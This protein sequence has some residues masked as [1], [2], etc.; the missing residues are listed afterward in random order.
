[1]TTA[2]IDYRLKVWDNRDQFWRALPGP[3]TTLQ[4]AIDRA[5]DL[6]IPRECRIGYP[7][8]SIWQGQHMVNLIHQTPRQ[9]LTGLAIPAP[10]SSKPAMSDKIPGNLTVVTAKEAEAMP[11]DTCFKVCLVSM[12]NFVIDIEPMD[13][14]TMEWDTD[15]NLFASSGWDFKRRS[16]AIHADD[17]VVISSKAGA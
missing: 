13:K 10:R 8:V 4:A 5:H 9:A 3:E 15:G 2:T 11:W 16:V 7:K 1:M 17:Y 12:K 6:L 14:A